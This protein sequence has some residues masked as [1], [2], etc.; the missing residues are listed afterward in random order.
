[1][2]SSLRSEGGHGLSY[3]L[4]DSKAK[5]RNDGGRSKGNAMKV[6]L[7]ESL[8]GVAKTIS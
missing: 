2:A 4:G 5:L 3:F 7:I 8:T 1:M 6:L